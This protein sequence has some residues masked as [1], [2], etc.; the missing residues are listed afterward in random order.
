MSYSR[1][2]A[3]RMPDPSA[4]IIFGASGDLTRRKLVPAI[5]HL[6][7]QGRLPAEFVLVGVARSELDDASFRQQMREALHEF[8]GQLDDRQVEF[9]LDRLFYLC[10]DPKDPST[11]QRLKEKLAQLDAQRGTRGNYCFY[12]SVPPQVYLKIVEGLGQVGLHQ[13]AVCAVAR[14]QSRDTDRQRMSVDDG[15]FRIE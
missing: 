2:A 10:G 4:L 1:P 9:F 3:D 8:V 12:C 15:R 14:I 11:H 13:D 5:W 6:D 7:R